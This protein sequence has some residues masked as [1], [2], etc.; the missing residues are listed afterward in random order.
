V[1]NIGERG[2]DGGILCFDFLEE[3]R[4]F[5]ERERIE[6]GHG[7]ACEVPETGLGA[8]AMA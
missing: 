4:E 6:F 7:F 2:L 3:I 5:G 1:T 8:V